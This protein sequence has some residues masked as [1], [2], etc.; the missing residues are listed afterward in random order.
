MH[1]VTELTWPCHALQVTRGRTELI[2][3]SRPA[4][5]VTPCVL[6]QADNDAW[7]SIQTQHNMSHPAI[8]VGGSPSR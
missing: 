4:Q 7:A 8:D 5:G 2:N 1:Y 3:A 6:M